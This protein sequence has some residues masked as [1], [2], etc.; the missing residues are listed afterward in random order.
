MVLN[1]IFREPLHIPNNN[2][3]KPDNTIF[4]YNKK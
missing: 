4:I 1:A 3:R 2:A